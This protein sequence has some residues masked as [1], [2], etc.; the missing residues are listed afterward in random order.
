[1][2]LHP[3]GDLLGKTEA[4]KALTARVRRLAEL[5]SLYVRTAPRELATSSRVKGC[6]AGTLFVVADNAAVAAKLKQLA[7]RLLAAI[8]ENEAEINQIRI[9]VQ[10]AG[11]EAFSPRPARK[12][13]LPAAAAK[14]FAAL[15]ATLP[16]SALKAA[17]SRLA[18]RHGAA[19]DQDEALEHVQHHHDDHHNE[20]ELRDAPRPR[21]VA[22][23]AG[24]EVKTDAK[25]HRK[26]GE[27]RNKS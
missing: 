9:E 22:P 15:A 13:P 21:E 5:Q 18:K 14:E 12:K 19:L 23:V 27:H 3:F 26:Q 25:R 17:L 2:P 11:R 20:R 4:L 1:M 6:R 8:R 7:P 10:V 16:D 24:V